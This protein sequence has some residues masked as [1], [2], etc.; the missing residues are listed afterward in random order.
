LALTPDEDDDMR[1][2]KLTSTVGA[3][4]AALCFAAATAGAQTGS[5]ANGASTPASAAQ[6]NPAATP[7]SLPQTT[8]GAT[9]STNPAMPQTG[10]SSALSTGAGAPAMRPDTGA[11]AG[12]YDQTSGNTGGHNW[13]W[14]GIFGLLGLFG[15]RSGSRGPITTIRDT[16]RPYEAPDVV[17]RP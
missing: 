1:N 7:Q 15:L 5:T 9:P 17:N 11:A 3:A 4:F 2:L 8:P 14:V 12:T 10:D 13:G 16:E 6:T